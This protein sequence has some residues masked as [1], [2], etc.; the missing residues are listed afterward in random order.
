MK[1]ATKLALILMVAALLEACAGAP[2][3]TDSQIATLVAAELE[4]GAAASDTP[5]ASATIEAASPTTEAASDGPEVVFV[6]GGLFEAAE[7]ELFMQRIGNPFID[8]HADLAGHPPLLTMTVRHYSED[9]AFIY[10]IEAIFETGVYT[11]WLAP[12]SGGNPDWWLPDCMGPCPLSDAF[13]GA[14]PEIVGTLEP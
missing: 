9:P 3:D 12:G 4:A 8:Y 7:R 11:G 14:Y 1:T 10:T 13:R 2:A 6:P 5:A